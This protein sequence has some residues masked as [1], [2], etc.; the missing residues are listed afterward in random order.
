M[1]RDSRKTSSAATSVRKTIE[2]VG[3]FE[4]RSPAI[5]GG[6]QKEWQGV[7][8]YRKKRRK[9]LFLHV[10]LRLLM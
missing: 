1:E 4:I 10:C 6:G 2:R 9:A 5:T 7:A 3:L 8:D